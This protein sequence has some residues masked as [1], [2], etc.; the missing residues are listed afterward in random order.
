M[1][2]VNGLWQPAGCS[3][4]E[5]RATVLEMAA[6]I[7]HRGPDDAG[8][9]VDGAA[10]IAL[11]HR[12]LSIVDLSA[13][14]HQPM[15]SAGGRYVI[16]YNGEIYNH[17]DLR[18]RL[19]AAAGQPLAWRGHSDTET[20]LAGFEA[21]GVEAT[22]QAAI[23]MFAIALWDR[24]E[25]SLT[26]ARDRIGEKPLY[27]GW[28]GSGPGRTLL[29]GSELKALR[30]HPAFTASSAA[31]IDRE[32][33][34]LYMRHGYVPA[35]F[36]IHRGL[37]KVPPGHLLV[38]RGT[39]APAELRCYWAA[40]EVMLRGHANPL[41]VGPEEA[42]D[43]LEDLLRGAVR[44][45]MVA[46]VPL[47]AFLSGGI[48]SSTVVALMQAQSATPVRTF[49]IG[50][51]EQGYDE[52]RHAKAVAAHLG[53]DH[54][55]LY[56]TPAQAL[57]VVPALPDMYDEPF[58]DSSQIPTH[59]VAA[60]AR[61][62]VT[63]ALSGDAGDELFCGYNRYQVTHDLWSRIKAVPRPLRRAFAAALTAVP[64]QAW[65]RL[66]HGAGRVLP[67][68]RR[69]NRPGEKLH[70]GARVM[71]SG[72][73]DALYLHTVSQWSEPELLV[74]GVTE[75]STVLTGAGHGLQALPDVPR[76]MAYDLLTY[77]PED[78]LV[79]VD[80]AAMA[81]SLE[82]RVPL[83]DH[84]VVEFAWQLP[85]QYKLREGVGKWVLRQ[86]LYRHVPRALI[87]RPK[88]G[89][90]VPIDTW[91]RGPLRPWAEHLLEPRRLAEDG[92]LSPAPIRQAW[93]R[94][95]EGHANLQ[96]PL[97]N[98]LMFQAWRERQRASSAPQAAAA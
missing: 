43:R 54:T 41:Q 4:E 65:D 62:S 64:E 30:A 8:A 45:Q 68:A 94:H 35:P 38:L 78:I 46:D 11:G 95:L 66:A 31:E 6:R 60:L 25:R 69:F 86:V 58:G 7:A 63:V 80:R 2:G 75:P 91:L 79:K 47:G 56:V 29:F 81:V 42:V 50:F 85:L 10:G 12:R 20:L 15:P 55:E 51:H 16:A 76:M 97:W 34:V 98:V 33:L 48:D 82:T 17:L 36:T 90:G 71:H 74:P 84:R 22:L 39:S 72:N 93:Q 61:R 5:A 89:F 53:T 49:S 87:D 73:A 32:A 1:C 26:L 92:L 40:G 14:G 59:L 37:R 57:D 70:K 27:H 44:Q 67:M 83:L 21:W 88:M 13:A 24:Q 9:W 18:R 19:E 52:A 28:V 77:L 23:G 96:Y 3:A